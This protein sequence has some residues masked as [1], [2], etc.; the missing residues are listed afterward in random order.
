MRYFCSAKKGEKLK[1]RIIGR[2]WKVKRDDLD[3]LVTKL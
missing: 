1:A 2:G 3:Q